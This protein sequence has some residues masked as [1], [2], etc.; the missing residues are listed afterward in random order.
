MPKGGFIDPERPDLG[1]QSCIEL[2]IHLDLASYHEMG[3][4]SDDMTPNLDSAMYHL[5]KSA[6]CGIAEALYTLAR[7]YLQQSHDRFAGLSVEVSREG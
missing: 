6:H 1:T 7:I 3:R 5:A 4:F 2:Q